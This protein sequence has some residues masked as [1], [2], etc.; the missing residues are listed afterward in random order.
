MS[1]S[2]LTEPASSVLKILQNHD[3]TRLGGDFFKNNAILST[4]HEGARDAKMFMS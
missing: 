2:A 1:L 3:K 4:P